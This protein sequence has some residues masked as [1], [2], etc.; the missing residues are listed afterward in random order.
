[1]S[2]WKLRRCRIPH[3]IQATADLVDAILHDDAQKNSASTIKAVY[4][5]ALAKM[6]TSVCDLEQ[7]SLEKR[8]MMEQAKKIGMPEDWVHLRHSI[9]HGQ[10]PG[11]RALEEAVRDAVPWMWNHFWRYL[12]VEDRVSEEELRSEFITVLA[13][14]RRQRRVAITRKQ[15]ASLDTN[16]ASQSSKALRRLCKN[17]SRGHEILISVLL[18]DNIIL[19]SE[20]QY[21]HATS[22]C[23]TR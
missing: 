14:F 1:V 18:H 19:P 9:T 5:S 4:A 15:D 21:V 12:D 7:D 2:T 11:L 13:N 22:I 8:S 6:V 20:K 16:L 3:S 10:T 23:S 17:N